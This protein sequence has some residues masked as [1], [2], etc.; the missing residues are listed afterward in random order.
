MIDQILTVI[1]L[2]TCTF[3]GW[4]LGRHFMRLNCEK[5]LWKQE[6]R[7]LELAKEFVDRDLELTDIKS[8][9]PDRPRLTITDCYF[10]TSKP[11]ANQNES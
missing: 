9:D 5:L 2:G 6:Q 10:H 7:Y 11:K 8:K 4:F 3:C 1:S